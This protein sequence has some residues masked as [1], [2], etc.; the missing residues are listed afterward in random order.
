LYCGAVAV[1][2][3]TLRIESLRYV[4]LCNGGDQT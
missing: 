1:C 2:C 3:D 4:V